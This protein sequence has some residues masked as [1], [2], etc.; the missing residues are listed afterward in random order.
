[1][2]TKDIIADAEETALTLCGFIEGF[3]ATRNNESG[4][5]F[6]S[7]GVTLIYDYI[8]LLKEQDAEP[9]QEKDSL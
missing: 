8:T 7:H 1:M 4:T 3:N 6:L 5:I 9:I 2:E